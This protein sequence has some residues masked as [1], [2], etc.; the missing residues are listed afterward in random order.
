LAHDVCADQEKTGFGLKWH[1][2]KHTARTG[3]GAKDHL[4]QAGAE[5]G[6]GNT[7]TH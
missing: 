4:M 3:T 5:G 2:A 1:Y 6:G 7:F